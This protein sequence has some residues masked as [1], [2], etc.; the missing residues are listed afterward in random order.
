ML[1]LFCFILSSPPC[2]QIWV[3]KEDRDLERIGNNFSKYDLI[4]FSTERGGTQYETHASCMYPYKTVLKI[5]TVRLLLLLWNHS[6]CMYCCW[7]L[8]RYKLS[9]SLLASAENRVRYHEK[10]KKRKKH[11]RKEQKK[12]A[13][14][15]GSLAGLVRTD[16]DLACEYKS[17]NICRRCAYRT[18]QGSS[19][20]G[21]QSLLFAAS[22]E[23][24]CLS[25]VLWISSGFRQ[26]LQP[27]IN[28]TQM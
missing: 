4:R 25:I 11:K 18:Y 7:Y 3:K 19:H 17:F 12:N 1:R 9:I 22:L 14:A 27:R 26:N 5:S 13:F 21:L 10:E 8:S 15:S 16:G 20:I 24:F 23:F 2:A 28:L 6:M